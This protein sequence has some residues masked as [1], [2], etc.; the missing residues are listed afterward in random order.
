MAEPSTAAEPG[1]TPDLSATYGGLEI[2]WRRDVGLDD[3]LAAFARR[4]RCL[5]GKELPGRPRRPREPRPERG[6]P[7]SRTAGRHRNADGQHRGA[8][9]DQRRS[10]DL[11]RPGSADRPGLA[12]TDSPASR[13][14]SADG[15]G[16]ALTGCQADGPVAPVGPGDPGTAVPADTFSR[17]MPGDMGGATGGELAADPARATLADLAGHALINPGASLAGWL[18]LAQPEDLDDAGLV[19]SISAWRR[20]TSWAQACEIAAVA[21]LDRRRAAE[22]AERDDQR[23]TRLELSF[24]PSELALALALS[25]PAAADWLGLAVRLHRRLPATLNALR[26]GHID[27]AKAR[28]IDAW[29][30]DLDD[31]LAAQVEAKVLERAEEQ[32][33]GQLCA[34]LQRAVINADPAAAERR[35]RRAEREARVE[36]FGDPEGTASLAGRHLPAGEAAAAFARITALAQALQ[37]A[38]DSGGIDERRARVFLALLR[39][40][41]PFI[42]PPSGPGSGPGEDPPAPPD[43]GAPAGTTPPAESDSSDGAAPSAGGKPAAGSKPPVGSKPPADGTPLA[44]GTPPEAGIPPHLAGGSPPG[45]LTLTVPLRTLAGLSTE[46]GQLSRIGAVTAMVA[47]QVATTAAASPASTWQIVVAG[48]TGEAIAVTGL[49]RLGN[50]RASPQ[51]ARTAT[52]AGG[53]DG[54]LRVVL[55]VPAALAASPGQELR[56]RLQNLGRLGDILATAVRS[57]AD[58]CAVSGKTAG[59]RK[60]RSAENCDHQQGVRGY[61]V[62]RGMRLLVEARDRTCGFPPCRQPAWRTDMDHTIP[63]H[64]GGP[65][66]PCNIHGECRHHHILKQ[67]RRWKLRQPGPGV[68]IWTTPARLWYQTTPA[69]Y[70]A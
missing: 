6:G 53:Y 2:I 30:I 24:V 4:S 48:E 37:A 27:L 3:V 61:R 65:T 19:T 26:L 22:A 70:A 15:T 64:R 46:P 63:Y 12:V 69:R 20:L 60:Y 17:R 43:R 9:N 18:S 39:G 31:Q 58:A 11:S 52:L 42:P 23:A 34:A 29:T 54:A 47:R 28:L 38:G 51:A 36:L 13:P 59:S 35:R 7:G 5:A 1:V 21:E 56:D 41:L 10:A 66:C 68:L 16:P 55:V 50:A 44:D 40:T 25:E 57:A 45:S 67:Q 62:P 14:G 33:R 49:R 8:E 32:T